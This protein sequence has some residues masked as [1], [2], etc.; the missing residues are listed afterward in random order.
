MI[1]WPS[2]FLTWDILFLIPV[3]WVSPVLAPIIVS[4]TMIILA[5]LI[6]QFPKEK[7]KLREWLLLVL[8]AGIIYVSFAWDY[9]LLVLKKGFLAMKSILLVICLDIFAN[10]LSVP[11]ASLTWLAAK[12]ATSRFQQLPEVCKFLRFPYTNLDD[13]NEF[14]VRKLF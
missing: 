3:T 1:N 11:V 10:V 13:Y 14:R 7:V 9:S 12:S 5:F 6:I 4:I 2:S 8:G